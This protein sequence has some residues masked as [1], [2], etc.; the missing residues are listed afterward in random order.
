MQPESSSDRAQPATLQRKRPVPLTV[1][2]S[3]ISF[4]STLLGIGGGTFIVPLLA[5][6]GGIRLKRAVATS[7]ALVTVAVTSGLIAQILSRP[8]YILWGEAALLIAGAFFGAPV[9]RWLLGIIPQSWFRYVMALFFLLISGRMLLGAGVLTTLPEGAHLLGNL[10]VISDPATIVFSLLTG[11]FAGLAST[12]FGVGGGIVIVP[13]LMFAYF[14]MD[15]ETARATSLAAI[16]PISAWGALLHARGGNV[17]FR[18]LPPLLP[19]MIP[20][21][22]AG[23]F[24]ADMIDANALKIVFA[25]LLLLLSVKLIMEALT[26]RVVERRIRERMKR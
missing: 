9:G 16:V 20:A 7:L 25:V 17:E 18:L 21:A 23:V 15:F 19:F 1:G 24:V 14:G 5:A 3:I 22:I 10:P 6:W 2:I 11:F 26:I 8:Q 4:A 13:A 12:L